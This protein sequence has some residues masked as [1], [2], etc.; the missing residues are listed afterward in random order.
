MLVDQ[1]PVQVLHGHILVLE[2]LRVFLR[3]HQQLAEAPA[4][5]ELVA[6]AGNLWEFI[7]LPLDLAL[8]RGHIQAHVGQKFGHQAV[9]LAQE[10]QMEVLPL[11]L[12][13][14]VLYGDI[15]AVRHRRLGVLGVLVKIHTVFLLWRSPAGE[16]L[17]RF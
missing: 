10:G 8:Q 11:Q 14:S 6:A 5:V 13:L 1:G 2:L 7:D 3:R 17:L 9:L 12:L 16:A 15:L 4:G